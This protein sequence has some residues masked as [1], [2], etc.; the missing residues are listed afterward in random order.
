MSVLANFN[1]FRT[2]EISIVN[3][4]TILYVKSKS[5]EIFMY[6]NALNA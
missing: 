6:I 2:I 3:N 1:Y 4:C 5:I